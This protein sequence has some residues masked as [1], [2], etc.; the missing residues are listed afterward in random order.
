MN[1]TKP[2]PP[3]WLISNIAE[4]SKSASKVYFVYILFLAYSALTVIGTTDRQLI[5]KNEAVHLPIIN[6]NVSLD[7]FFML[8]PLIAMLVFVY[9]QLYLGRLKGLIADIRTNYTTTE[10]RRL[11][12]WMIN[13][14]EDP[15]PG[16]MGKLQRLA[17]K[18]S[19]WFSLPAMLILF[20]LWFV[21]KHD[22]VLSYIVGIYPIIGTIIV[23]WF[24]CNYEDWLKGFLQNL[25]KVALALFALTFEI[26]LLFFIIPWASEGKC[27]DR[28]S[29]F[30][31]DLSYQILV[32]EP[33]GEYRTIYLADFRG[34]HLEGANLTSSILKR[35]DLRNAYLQRAQ[36]SYSN[37]EGSNLYAANLEEASL[38]NANLQNA[39]LEF[40]NLR[41]ADFSRTNLEK[42]NLKC[43]DLRN[44]SFAGTN[45]KSSDLSLS[46]LSFALFDIA[47]TISIPLPG[48][49][50][51][52]ELYNAKLKFADLRNARFNGTDFTGTDLEGANLEGV[53]F[54]G[55]SS[56]TIEQLSKVR[57]LYK[58]ESRPPSP[59][60]LIQDKIL[61]RP[62]LPSLMK[63]LRDNYPSLFEEPKGDK[64][65]YGCERD[66]RG[67]FME[68]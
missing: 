13:I 38:S 55:V 5:L 49:Q 18:F 2:D 30:C 44:A 12:P 34:V 40:A 37:L 61:L 9:L 11:Y 64:E 27:R 42:A 26:L 4:V 32:T 46:D 60:E 59:K 19:L 47:I 65:T 36:L 8:A 54:E 35:A 56:L 22:P 63:Q 62:S 45:L 31:V 41:K 20:A 66:K 6:I 53:Y 15:E 33:K 58:V 21:K 43:A 23:L 50:F 57:T 3:D 24:W 39:N 51:R 17:V 52:T 14:A 16:F 68:L 25:D 29:W 28:W 7:G 1:E 48:E 67:Y 10:K